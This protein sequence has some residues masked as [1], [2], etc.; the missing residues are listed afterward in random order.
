MALRES[1]KSASARVAIGTAQLGMNYGVAN[2]TG[3]PSEAEAHR[4]VRSAVELGLDWFDTAAVY[5]ESEA[6]LG[7]AFAAHGLR[8]AVSVV[9]KGRL[10]EQD[11]ASLRGAVDAS[12]QRLGLGRLDVWMLHDERQL[13]FW[14]RACS[15]EAASLIGEAR[16]GAF[17]ISTY[18]PARA[19]EA[20]EGRGFAAVQFPASPMDRRFLR[21]E[22]LTRL[23][24]TGAALFARSIYLQGLCL[25][26]P[27]EVPG[28]ISRGREAVGTLADFCRTRG[29]ERDRFCLHYVLQRTRRVGAR[30]VIGVE[31]AEQLG[32]TAYLVASPP[33]DP[34]LLD[35]WDVLWPADVDDL[36][37]PFRWTQTR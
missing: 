5:G 23:S 32:R 2:R 10:A 31:S 3:Q 22:V 37:L 11:P 15:L 14:D 19:I 4:L 24:R 35:E 28:H 7:R 26:D 29:I 27:A 6:I 25:M 1:S 20:V 8:N 21:D 16:V 34:A 12:L 9:S 36:V 30:L 17:G 18:S 13:S 33:I